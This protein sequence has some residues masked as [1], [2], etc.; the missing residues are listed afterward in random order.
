MERVKHDRASSKRAKGRVPAAVVLMG[1]GL[2]ANCGN[3]APVGPDVA[4]AGPGRR[5][6]VGGIRHGRKRCRRRFF[7]GLPGVRGA[8]CGNGHCIEPTES[9]PF[10]GNGGPAGGY[11]SKVCETGDDCGEPGICV[12]GEERKECYLLCETGPQGVAIDDPLDPAKCRGREDVRCTEFPEAT[13]CVP[14]CGSDS[15]CDGGRVCDP[16]SRSCVDVLNRGLPMGAA[17]DAD[18]EPEQCAGYCVESTLN[19]SLCTSLCV[20]GG[21]ADSLD[22]GGLKSGACAFP[23]PGYGAGDLGFCTPA[24]SAQSACQTPDYWCFGLPGLTGVYVE[25]GFC[26]DADPC[27]G[28]QDDCLAAH[29]C[30]D[31]PHGPY[32]IDTAF[33]L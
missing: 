25:N 6:V 17:C 4:T 9:V 5:L 23:P 33:P 20:L 24:C 21:A 31:T 16:R 19:T 1:S 11:C 32:C 22:C 15:E 3:D 12:K 28:G 27:P 8:D 30:T 26:R 14:S 29:V 13:V 7:R 2:C 18:A 10:L